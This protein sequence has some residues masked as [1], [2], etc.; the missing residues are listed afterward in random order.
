MRRLRGKQTK[1][2]REEDG[3]NLREEKKKHEMMEPD[4]GDVGMKEAE[5]KN[6]DPRG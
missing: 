2:A 4:S 6:K 1:R 5:G 3:G